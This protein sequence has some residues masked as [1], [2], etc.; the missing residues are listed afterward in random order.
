MES[1]LETFNDKR[2]YSTM[3]LMRNLMKIADKLGANEKAWLKE[4]RDRLAVFRSRNSIEH[5]LEKGNSYS[6]AVTFDIGYEST[7]F[8]VSQSLESAINYA[9]K[10]RKEDGKRIKRIEI[11]REDKTKKVEPDYESD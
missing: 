9:E 11:K 2:S 8:C 1:E 3:R 7:F 5:T 10:K 6:C 4:A